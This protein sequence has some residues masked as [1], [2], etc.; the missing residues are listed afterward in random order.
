MKQEIRLRP[1][2]VLFFF[3]LLILIGISQE[4]P[5]RVLMMS[6]QICLSCIGIG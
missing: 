4:E 2:M 3:L 5:L 1:F 6:T